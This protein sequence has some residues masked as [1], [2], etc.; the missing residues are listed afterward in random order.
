MN[1][2]SGTHAAA[3]EGVP[4]G[5][6]TGDEAAAILEV[7]RQTLYAY[8]S[9][10]LLRSVPSGEGRA[11][12]YARADLLRL[13]AR[14]D[15]RSGHGPV[16]ASALRWGEPVLE[17]AISTIDTRGPVYRGVPAVELAEQGV[18][19]ERVAAL[20]WGEL[21]AAAVRS[22]AAGASASESAAGGARAGA[23]GSRG[24]EGAAGG[25]RA[26]AA[27]VWAARGLG[28]PGAKLAGLLPDDASPLSALM[29]GVPAIGARDAD[30]FLVSGASEAGLAR[31]LVVR[32]AALLSLP[33]RRERTAAALGERS[34]ARAV[35]AALGV[36]A[37]AGAVRAVNR[38]L[39]L[40][41]DHELNPSTFAVRVAASARA[42]LYACVSAGLN[43]LS[44][45]EHGGVCD[46][47][48]VLVA[49]ARAAGRPADVVAERARRG[50]PIPGFGHTLYPGGDPRAA[51]LLEVASEVAPHSET[52]GVVRALAK[53]MA[54]AGHEPP[55]LD[56][57]L[58]AVA[59]AAG[60]PPGGAAALFAVGRSAGWIAHAMEQ[61]KAGFLLRPRARYTGP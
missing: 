28:A 52:L 5:Y 47:V 7:K 27:E 31:S 40:S 14:H 23:G 60:L 30:R 11:H 61:R 38:A 29:V 12:L 21:D 16:A 55:S 1:Q 54:A 58:V 41:A 57:G 8:A 4:D 51:S 25:A 35:L 32:M 43:V 33:A 15:A 37:S 49:E 2:P 42:D 34:V 44:G 36:R 24:G 6:V 20:L 19:F 13:K 22:G 53:A 10:G 9:R 3:D 48:E 56:M 18:A 45:P 46:R 26:G 59:S 39:V 50:E 17:T